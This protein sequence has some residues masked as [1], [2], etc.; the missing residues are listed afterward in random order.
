MSPLSWK[1]ALH[2]QRWAADRSRA[3]RRAWGVGLRALGEGAFSEETWPTWWQHRFEMVPK[4]FQNGTNMA[5]KLAL[6]ASWRPLGG[7]L[8]LLKRLGRPRGGFQGLMGRYWKPLG[9]PL[10]PS[11]SSLGRCRRSFGRQKGAQRRPRASP[12]GAQ[13]GLEQEVVTFAE[14]SKLVGLLS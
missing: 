12:N 1:H 2:H 10:E 9:A 11:W 13:K 5:A 7:L 4:W 14:T 8:E 6:E 3:F